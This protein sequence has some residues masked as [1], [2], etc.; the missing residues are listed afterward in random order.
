[1]SGWK[2]I[3]A[4]AQLIV[5][6]LIAIVYTELA[7]AHA[8][9]VTDSAT[10]PRSDNDGIKTGPCG[11][12]PRSQ[13]P[14]VFTP[15]QQI[16]VEWE[17]TINHPGYYRIAFSPA[18]DQGYDDNVLYQVDDNQDG[19]DVPHYYNATI[20]LP[21]V[22]CEDCSLQLIQYMTER[23]PPTLYYSCADI[24]LVADNPPPDVQNALIATG[25]NE[26]SIAWQYPNTNDLQVMILQD[27][28]PITGTPISGVSYSSGDNVDAASVLYVGG[29]SQVIA[30]NLSPGQNYYFKI[31]AVDSNNRYSTGI[32]L[33]QTVAQE[34]N[35]S[36]APANVQNFST[37]VVDNSVELSWENPVDDFYKVLILWDANP[38]IIDPIDSNRYDAG[39]LIGTAR[40]VFN[41]L[42][43]AATVVDLLGGRTHYFK[44]YTHDSS[45]NYSPGIESSVFLAAGGVNQ[46]P[47]LS[48]VVSQNGSPVTTVYQDK[49]RVTISVIIEDDSD[50]SQATI[51][52]GGTDGRLVDLDNSP[53]SLTIDPVVLQQDA[54]TVFVAVADNGNPPETSTL[55]MNFVVTNAAGEDSMGA[56]SIGHLGLL[57]IL[58]LLQRFYIMRTR[59]GHDSFG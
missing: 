21:D 20:T 36:Q 11:N 12:Y 59:R 22:E 42:G 48:L 26:I 3:I 1:M 38:N 54:Y 13:D 53:D 2:K 35:D 51:S 55:T 41:G 18:G 4:V 49:G 28:A 58:L 19:S 25:N 10:P 29:A 57:L 37:S 23:N 39:D 50:V 9:F 52:W 24:R 56:G 31:F 45:F 34:L 43:N 15:G 6:M 32:E 46:K 33:Q 47:Q 7:S 5:L 17:E 27:T 40:V 30:S 44:I 14:V 16:T 8:R